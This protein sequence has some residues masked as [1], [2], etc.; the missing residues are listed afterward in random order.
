MLIQTKGDPPTWLD[1][2]EAKIQPEPMS[3]CW[4][5]IGAQLRTGHGMFFL[6]GKLVRAH[7]VSWELANGQ[8]PARQGVGQKCNVSCCVNPKHLELRSHKASVLGNFGRTKAECFL[9]TSTPLPDA[10]K[11][12]EMRLAWLA[13]IIDGEGSISLNRIRV[14]DLRGNYWH[15]RFTVRVANTDSAMLNE[16]MAIADLLG[17]KYFCSTYRMNP[18]TREKP[19]PGVVFTAKSSVKATL[20]AIFPY[21]ITKRARAELTLRAMA[22]RQSTRTQGGRYMPLENDGTFV[23][24]VDEMS[25]LNRRGRDE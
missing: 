21:L 2:F 11:P 17:I 8:I 14:K 15:A 5:W 24:Y 6:D 20:E 18:R 25:R 23:S 1:R 10:S 9:A 19:C 13:G 22:H 4:L 7:R 16:V 3:G 12:I